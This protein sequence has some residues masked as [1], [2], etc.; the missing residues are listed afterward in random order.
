MKRLPELCDD[1]TAHRH[2][3][4]AEDETL[5]ASEAAIAGGGVSI[6]ERPDVDLAIVDVPAGV[7]DA[8]GHRL[9][10]DWV[11]GLHPMAVHNA[12]DRLVVATAR[13]RRYDVELRYES[14]VQLRSRPLR[15]R[16]D[17]TALATRL[18]D[19]ER[20]DAVW[21]ATP[22]GGLVPRLVSGDGDSSIERGRF[23]ELLIDHLATAPPAWNPFSTEPGG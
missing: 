8:G 2:L 1:V 10:G 16:R 12:T 21:T 7:P 22:V 15:L 19:E 3:W 13:E 17:L 9:G 11:A 6:A 4:A 23:L 18:Q 14:W 20:G 5:T